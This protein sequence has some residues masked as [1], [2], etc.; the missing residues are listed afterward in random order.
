MQFAGQHAGRDVAQQTFDPNVQ[1]IGQRGAESPN[2]RERFFKSR[3][4]TECD[5]IDGGFVDRYDGLRGRWN[6]TAQILSER[7]ERVMHGVVR[8]PVHPE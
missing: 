2:I 1:R 6:G 7:H 8:P 4:F 3:V 5:S